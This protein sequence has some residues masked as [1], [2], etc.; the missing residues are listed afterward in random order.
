MD[1]YRIK[2]N[3][4]DK[5]L[6]KRGR[7]E[8]VI[9]KLSQDSNILA[10]SANPTEVGIGFAPYRY[11][12]PTSQHPNDIIHADLN[13]SFYV[14]KEYNLRKEFQTWLDE[15]INTDENYWGY[16]DDYATDISVIHLNENNEVKLVTEYYSCVPKTISELRVDFDSAEEL[17]LL[18]VSFVFQNSK[19]TN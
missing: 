1:I 7:F 5:G 8:I 4:I 14:D 17:M 12:G 11:F 3:V 6:A 18:D 9:P 10:K 19:I 13:I 15:I 2:E 16:R